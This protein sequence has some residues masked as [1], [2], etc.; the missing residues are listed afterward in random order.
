MH[1]SPAPAKQFEILK[2]VPARATAPAFPLSKTKEIVNCA[3]VTNRSL[4]ECR[5]RTISV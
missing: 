2:L 5:R 4:A 1:R 3:N